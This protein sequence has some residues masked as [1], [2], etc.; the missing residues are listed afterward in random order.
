MFKFSS[1]VVL[2]GIGYSVCGLVVEFGYS[3]DGLFGG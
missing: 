3:W 2:R 1:I